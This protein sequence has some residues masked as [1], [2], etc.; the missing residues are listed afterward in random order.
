M[1]KKGRKTICRLFFAL[2][3]L[4]FLFSCRTRAAK[5]SF[6]SSLDGIDALIN[7]RLYKEAV[8]ELGKLEKD[9]YSSWSQIGIFRRYKDC[10]ENGKAEKF[11]E[12]SLKKNPENL[13][14]RA[15]YSNFLLRQGRT[16]ES[17]AAGKK[18]QG[19][20]Y[21]SVY[22]ES[23]LKDLLEKSS[24]SSDSLDS[25]VRKNQIF[26]SEDYYPVYYDA[27]TGS[28]N[29]AWLRN[30]ALIHLVK[31]AYENAG[32]IKPSE[33]FDSLDAYFWALV[34]FDS[35]RF[36]DC[37]NYLEVSR[38]LLS[39]KMNRNTRSS[40]DYKIALLEAD[41][42]TS[43]KDEENAEKI[44]KSFIEGLSE[45]SGGWILP[46]DENN[47]NLR[48]LSVLFT[49]SAR[50]ALDNE[51]YEDAQKILL[52]TVEA[53]PDFVPALAL[54]ADFAY[55][56]NLEREKDFVQLEL[57]DS[58]FLSLDMEKYDSRVRIPLSDAVYRIQ[59]SI[60]R[61]KDP[62]LYIV[63]LDLRYKTSTDLSL[64]QKT[65][66]LWNI[67]EENAVSP[68]VYPE[69]MLDY[70]LS[71]LLKNNEA[72]E[73][74]RIYCKYINAKYGIES[75]GNLGNYENRGN[76]GI[77]GNHRKDGNFFENL[78]SKIHQIDS[79]ALEYGAYFASFMDRGDDATV[80]YEVLVY[81]QNGFDS[82]TVLSPFAAD[83][84]CINL[85]NIYSSMSQKDKAIDLYGKAFGRA[86]SLKLKSEIM[87]RMAQI[88]YAKMDLRNARRSAE[89][90]LTLNRNNAEARMLLNRIK[91]AI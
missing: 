32:T 53:W 71:F 79:V 68:S 74:W 15:V 52:F 49:N 62:L 12:K 22:S 57:S 23:V 91:A 13:E 14:L 36:G 39:N 34:M 4:P 17:V 58:G 67:L 28:G 73:A 7:Q 83:S 35:K 31:G 24:G 82:G 63:A 38:R 84:S 46:E 9:A 54:Y 26:R 41:S 72:D 70:A 60:K 6:T 1:K 66:D 29:N 50:W 77:G 30:C 33:V 45:N 8:Q 81:E 80:L 51:N 11:L 20:K 56:S 10:Q 43:L 88:Y 61:T 5:K 40:L 37:V 85:A 3:I 89:Y 44:R 65:A 76:N 47:E 16:S 86:T 55:R 78:V 27:Y 2:T 48:N 21:G 64:K 90:A 19:T 75:G 87:R 69:L 59:E 18:L 42:Y 25:A